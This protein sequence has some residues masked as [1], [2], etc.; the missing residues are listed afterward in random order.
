M[1]TRITAVTLGLALAVTTALSA[2]PAAP[3]DTRLVDAVKAGNT[4]AATALLAR[5]VDVNAPE[6]DGTTALHWAV[7]NDDQALVDRLIRA[8]A[9]AKAENR[10]GMTPIALACQNGSAPVVERLLKAGVS[11]NAT[12]PLGETALHLCSRTGKPARQ[13]K[14]AWT[15]EWDD[16]THPQPLGMPMQ[17]ILTAEALGRIDRAAYRKGS[18]AEK[19][20]NYFVGQ[21]V[22]SMNQTKTTAQVVF[23]MVDEFIEATQSLARQ[24][25]D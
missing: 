23:D 19:L 10:Y 15:E 25:E 24:L 13:L 21:I 7:R 16:P 14:S 17:L 18:G 4:A 20:A 9:N 6:A 8:G 3:R 1:T 22:G 12:G 11:A 2:A 5:K